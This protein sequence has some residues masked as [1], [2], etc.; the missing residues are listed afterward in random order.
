[1]RMSLRRPRKSDPRTGLARRAVGLALCVLASAPPAHADNHD[2]P[3]KPI[4]L[5]VGYA[6]GGSVD[7]VA[8]TVG[9]KLAERLKQ[10]VVVENIGGAGGTI[11][12]Q[13]AVAAKADGYTLL[14]GSGS[15]VSIARLTNP[16]TRYDG[17]KDLA[18]I[19]LIAT[20]PMVFVAGPK[21]QVASVDEMVRFAKA[22]PGQLAFASSGVGTP[23]HLAG[24][25]INQRAGIKLAHVPYKGAGQM[26]T[27]VVGGQIETSILVLSS[28]LP[29]I[30]AGK[31]RALGLTEARRSPA[32]PDIPALAENKAF[33]GVDMGVWFGLFAPAK[34]PRPIVER[35]HKELVEALGS[36]EVKDKLNEAGLQASAGTTPAEFAS[37]IRKETEKYRQIVTTAGI[38]E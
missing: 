19:S 5:V 30:K 7:L 8:R 23:L 35:L 25:M 22:N 20:A 1:M 31:M 26:V 17:E 9:S 34:T 11:G 16:N 6:A 24:E 21:L 37:F 14:L 29:H 2:F 33:Q 13:K 18:P 27:D 15:E 4:T 12:A 28:A 32:A 3:S 38:K 36:P 10:T